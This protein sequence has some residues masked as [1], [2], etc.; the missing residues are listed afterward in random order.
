MSNVITYL[1]LATKQILSPDP[2]ALSNPALLKLSDLVSYY[3]STCSLDSSLTGLF[4]I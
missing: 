4:P 2:Q 3:S 1:P